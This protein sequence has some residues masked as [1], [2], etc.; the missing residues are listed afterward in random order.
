M[1]WVDLIVVLALVQLAVFGVLVGRARGRYGV[2]AP[3]TTGN[4]SFERYYRVQVNTIELLVMFVPGCLLAVH[5]V[6]S[7]WVAGLG[8]VYLVGRL[9]YLQAYVSEP[10]RRGL[11]FGLS[12][13]PI[14]A[15]LGISL[16]GSL[17]ALARD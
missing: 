8:V 1:A 2:K 15:L 11:G 7:P 10:S 16:V 13:I 3:A 12:F 4:E 9:I 6:A 5:Y 17:L 14:I